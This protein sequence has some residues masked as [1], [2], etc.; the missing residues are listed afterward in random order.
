LNKGGDLQDLDTL[1][2][3]PLIHAI[4]RGNFETCKWILEMDP[5]TIKYPSE[6]GLDPLLHAA[7][8]KEWNITRELD[9]TGADVNAFG[10][11]HCFTCL[12]Y[13]AKN[14]Q[15]E[16]ALALLERGADLEAKNSHGS[17][18]LARAVKSE[19]E[20]MI[21]LL[22]EAGADGRATD[23]E[24]RGMLHLAAMAG[25]VR[26]AELLSS[27]GV[28]INYRDDLGRTSL[29]LC[30]ELGPRKFLRLDTQF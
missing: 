12:H 27:F 3:T 17:T 16:L 24:G 22:L 8:Y 9:R 18:P 10:P 21:R 29:Q 14:S 5:R 25:N 15:Y 13:A 20:Q 6:N 26:I 2:D 4:R 19:D 7:K 1:G 28:D 11:G 23:R 30:G